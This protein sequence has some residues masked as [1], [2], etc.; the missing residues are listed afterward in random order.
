MHMH[1]G[2]SPPP[3]LLLLSVYTQ[4]IRVE[5][6]WEGAVSLALHCLYCH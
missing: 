3:R 4:D 1:S 5:E 2:V 6:A